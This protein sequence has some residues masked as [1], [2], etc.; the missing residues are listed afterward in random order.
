MSIE[1]Q[2]GGS[3]DLR[4]MTDDD[5]PAVGGLVYRAIARAFRDHGQ[6]EPIA[7]EEEG[8]RL[9]RL[10]LTLDPQNAIVATRQGKLVAAGFLHVRDEVASL[11]PVVVEPEFQAQ[12]LGRLLVEQLSEQASRCASTRLFVD[13]FNM[14]AFGNVL[15]R[16]YIPRDHG[17]RLVALGGLKGPGMSQSIAPAPIRD[18]V[19]GDL[20][21]VV[22][23]DGSF[24]GG[25][26]ERD[27][28]ALLD[29]GAVGLIAEENGRVSGYLLAR[30][31]GSLAT[32]GPG[33]AESA[34]LLGKLL[35][36]LGELLAAR[37]NI[38]L[39]YLLASQIDVISEAFSMGFRATSLSV[40]M[41][42]G[43]YTPV[44]R[45]TAI[46]IPPDVV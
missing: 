27:F 41:V 9:A 23:F 4:P 11:G 7:G 30:V 21:T 29:A 42:R 34:D 33:G 10:Y 37:A 6:P 31:E 16:G 18:L 32:I 19:S 22:R 12:G 14:R 2:S 38:F 15:K 43:S 44:K 5:A 13:A 1:I 3:A 46:G 45:P 35:A 28:R 26:R 8:E 24:F 20:E 25:S 36:R 40:Y 17:I 39:A